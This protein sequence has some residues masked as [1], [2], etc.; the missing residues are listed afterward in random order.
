MDDQVIEVPLPDPPNL[1]F[2]GYPGMF[3]S[4]VKR[5]EIFSTTPSAAEVNIACRYRDSSSVEWLLIILSWLFN[6]AV[7]VGSMN[8]E[9]ERIWKET[10]LS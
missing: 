4:G 10:V 8:E 1:F 6:D 7:S 5:W 2:R 9:L 3:S